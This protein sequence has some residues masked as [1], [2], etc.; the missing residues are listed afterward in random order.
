MHL[1]NAFTNNAK[2][3]S[4]QSVTQPPVRFPLV[5]LSA[6]IWTDDRG[7]LFGC[8]AM[9]ARAKSLNHNLICFAAAP[10]PDR[11]VIRRASTPSSFPPAPFPSPPPAGLQFRRQP[12]SQ[13]A[14]RLDG[15][16]PCLPSESK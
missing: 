13:F 3:L 7:R 1:L 2:L 16:Q 8:V 11:V 9:N 12:I 14:W 5:R 6:L 15:C 4:R 10:G